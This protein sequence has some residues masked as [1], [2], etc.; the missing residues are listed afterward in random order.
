M[1]EYIELFASKFEPIQ[2]LFNTYKLNIFKVSPD[3]LSILKDDKKPGMF[4]RVIYIYIYIMV[5]FRR[6]KIHQEVE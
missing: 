2:K 5:H 1:K 6:G 4:K 3:L